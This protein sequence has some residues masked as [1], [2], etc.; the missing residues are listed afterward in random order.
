L[1]IL[2]L[3]QG[4]LDVGDGLKH[5]IEIYEHLR[6]FIF[7]PLKLLDISL[8]ADFK[9]LIFISSIFYF[10]AL[11]SNPK[12]KLI[13]ICLYSSV[14]F[15]YP[16]TYLTI[17]LI[18][19]KILYDFLDEFDMA[20]PLMIFLSFILLNILVVYFI[21][22]VEF[23]CI[24]GLTVIYWI[25]VAIYPKIYHVHFLKQIP[26]L[27][28]RIDGQHSKQIK[29][30]FYIY[31]TAYLLLKVIFFARR[32]RNLKHPVFLRF[33]KKLEVPS[34]NQELYYYYTWFA[35]ELFHVVIIIIIFKVFFDSILA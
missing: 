31:F 20:N 4:K 9:N 19:R 16:L 34:S 7:Y 5:L 12:A 10:S 23:F 14:L 24:L 32:K 15:I 33:I 29:H 17:V 6:E 27:F 26:F 3:L 2:S 13:G 1:G 8:S 11:R 30:N 28:I 25:S 22:V 35:K 21:I 18:P